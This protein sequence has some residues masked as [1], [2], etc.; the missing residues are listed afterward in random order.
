MQ[1]AVEAMSLEDWGESFSV[2][3]ATAS[4]EVWCSEDGGDS[5]SQ[6]AGNLPPISKGNH[7]ALLMSA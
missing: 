3:A 5:W 6:I 2:F 7:Y 4:G 1:S